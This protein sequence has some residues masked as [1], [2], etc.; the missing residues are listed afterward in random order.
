[1]VHCTSSL[2]HPFVLF[3]CLK[4]H[5]VWVTYHHLFFRSVFQ[6]PEGLASGPGTEVCGWQTSQVDAASLR[7]GSGETPHKLAL[8]VSLQAPQGEL[9]R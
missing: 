6:H 7:V 5:A 8:L 4:A 2:F 9:K 3:F 1:M